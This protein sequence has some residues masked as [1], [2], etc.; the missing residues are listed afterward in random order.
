MLCLIRV[1]NT[2][3]LEELEGD[4][5]V[6]QDFCLVFYNEYFDKAAK[7]FNAKSMLDSRKGFYSSE[8]DLYIGSIK[9]NANSR[10]IF[11]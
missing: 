5:T 1:Y 2:I 7:I 9:P 6:Y 8:Y 10:F 4:S 11:K 3:P